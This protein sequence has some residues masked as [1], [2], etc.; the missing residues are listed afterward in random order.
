MESLRLFV[1]A[2]VVLHVVFEA[3]CARK[4]TADGVSGTSDAKGR[5]SWA[6]KDSMYNAY[7]A[8]EWFS[9]AIVAFCNDQRIDN[10]DCGDF[11]LKDMVVP[12]KIRSFTGPSYQ[13][14][15]YVAKLPPMA[16]SPPS[17]KAS[18]IAAFRGSV[19]LGNW[20][21]NAGFL[22]SSWPANGS[23][24]EGSCP[25]CQVHSGFAGAYAELRP[26]LLSMLLEFGCREV[27]TVG[28]SLGGA[29]ATLAAFDL[30]AGKQFRSLQI[31][32]PP[33]YLYGAPRVGNAAFQAAFHSWTTHNRRLYHDRAQGEPAIPATD[34][35][36]PEVF[37]PLIA[38]A[39]GAIRIVER[40][41]VVPRLP[42]R[43]LGYRHV[44][45]EVWRTTTEVSW[46]FNNPA[47]QYC[48]LDYCL[49]GAMDDAE[50]K[51]WCA[52][53][54]KNLGVW[55]FLNTQH[56]DYLGINMGTKDLKRDHPTCMSKALPCPV[57][58][59]PSDNYGC[60]DN[61]Y[62]A[63]ARSSAWRQKFPCQCPPHM[64]LRGTAPGCT[65]FLGQE[66]FPGNLSS[67]GA[68]SCE[69]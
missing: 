35:S 26:S 67:R 23:G 19:N 55:K 30:R 9:Y 57:Q 62:C 43:R 52:S 2:M 15:F 11:C 44:G 1:C 8:I 3:E 53:R 41:D 4:S 50:Q 38:D 20:Q 22:M 31:F 21:G 47:D 14:Q 68:C 61:V 64:V 48:T 16:R 25:G 5:Q 7:D 34:G 39:E 51:P 40:E 28:H 18:C 33:A 32:V 65:E 59:P 10:W 45:L 24:E 27:R 29:M 56:T 66:Y 60:S 13:V 12:H 37:R 46:L 49:C 42:P 58:L 69:P 6:T 63:K 36:V 17:W 54:I